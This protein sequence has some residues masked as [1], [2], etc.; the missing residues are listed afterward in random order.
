MGQTLVNNPRTL[1]YTT[2]GG[3]IQHILGQTGRRDDRVSHNSAEFSPIFYFDFFFFAF[4]FIRIFFGYLMVLV[5]AASSPSHS[6]D[7][8]DEHTRNSVTEVVHAFPGLN[9][10]PKQKIAC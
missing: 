8:L 6:L 2:S 4:N 5:V 3:H 9:L 7:T 1:F 10:D